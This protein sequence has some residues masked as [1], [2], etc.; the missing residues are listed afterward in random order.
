M[1]IDNKLI[2]KII[3]IIFQF[4]N[5]SKQEYL[6]ILPFTKNRLKNS[7]SWR[8]FRALTYKNAA[9]LYKDHT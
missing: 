7:F 4:S 8:R 5:K 2:G 9:L 3:K 6:E 1:I